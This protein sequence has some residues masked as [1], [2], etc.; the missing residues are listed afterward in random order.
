MTT[1]NILGAL[2]KSKESKQYVNMTGFL[3]YKLSKGLFSSSKWIKSRSEVVDGILRFKLGEELGILDF[4]K[5]R[6]NLTVYPEK[7][8]F[9]LSLKN[10]NLKKNFTFKTLTPETFNSW[11]MILR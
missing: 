8:K 6:F 5:F 11:I 7:L 10:N 9:L 3:F 2:D 4:H 1:S